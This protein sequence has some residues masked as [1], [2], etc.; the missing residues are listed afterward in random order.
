MATHENVSVSIYTLFKIET[1][2]W[3]E[4]IRAIEAKTRSHILNYVNLKWAYVAVKRIT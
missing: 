1:R 3:P 2:Q 4:V